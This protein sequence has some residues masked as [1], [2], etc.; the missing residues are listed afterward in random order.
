MLVCAAT[1]AISSTFSGETGLFKPVRAV[2]FQL[3][4]H[5]NGAGG[6][7]LAVGAD[8]HLELVPDR[9]ADSLEYPAYMTK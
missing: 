5:A 3:G 6:A 1:R 4:S 2:S 9:V 7:E 8:G